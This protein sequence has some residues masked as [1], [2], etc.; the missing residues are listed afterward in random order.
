[1][2]K[3][4]VSLA[5]VWLVFL[6]TACGTNKRI[7][8]GNRLYRVKQE[9]VIIPTSADPSPSFGVPREFLEVYEV[10]KRFDAP[11][12]D[13][14]DF[15]L[16]NALPAGLTPIPPVLIPDNVLKEY[17]Q[18]LPATSAA[19]GAPAY[20]K[21]FYMVASLDS[22]PKAVFRY[23]DGKFVVQAVN[24]TLKIRP[25]PKRD[26]SYYPATYTNNQIQAARDSFPTQA[27]GGVNLGL[28]FG[29][30]FNYNKFRVTKD[31]F[32]R[33]TNQFSVTPAAM[34]GTGVTD[35]TAT[36]TR[37]PKLISRKLPFFSTGVMVML[38]FNNLNIGYATGVDVAI[39][40]HGDKWIYSGQQW[41]GV[42]IALDVIK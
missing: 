38:G 12:T 26:L 21:P 36:N 13:K 29:Y 4:G 14:G 41:H 17:A 31:A 3:S 2:N 30:K 32:G 28:A 5:F 24:I 39:G 23:G 8:S 1:M 18:F 11:L 37:V 35:I 33:N 40:P 25:Q 19:T 10:D 20:G 22:D 16:F 9:M 27:E 34:I 42:V 7:Y 6:I 15:L